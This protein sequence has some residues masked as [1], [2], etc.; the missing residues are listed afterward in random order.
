MVHTYFQHAW[1]R[2]SDTTIKLWGVS[3]EK[4]Q[5]TLTSHGDYVKALTYSSD[6]G[7]LASA[8]LDK[9]ICIWDVEASQAPVAQLSGPSLYLLRALRSGRRRS[10][11]RAVYARSRLAIYAP[12]PSRLALTGGLAP[13]S[14]IWGRGDPRQLHSRRSSEGANTPADSAMGALSHF[15]LLICAR[16]DAGWGGDSLGISANPRKCSGHSES[17]RVPCARTPRRTRRL[18]VQRTWAQ[19]AHT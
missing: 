12:S 16:T 13:L 18:T 3:A 17:V 7:F 15:G 2:S 14:C 1:T 6:R 10:H 4:C 19:A 8:G 11:H 9:D 5:H